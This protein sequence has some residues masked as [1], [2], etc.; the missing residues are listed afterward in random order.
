MTEPARGPI[1][2]FDVG[3][4]FGAIRDEAVAVFTGLAERGAF[5]LG[6]ELERFEQEFAEY[7]GAAHCVGICDGT[8]ALR[9]ALL[10]LDV[11]PG[12]EVVTA[13]L[14]FIAT[15][16]AIAGTGARVVL[17]DVDPATRTLDPGAVGAVLTERTR[18]VLPVHLY[19]RPAPMA[20]IG[21]LAASSG[22]SVVEDAAQAHGATLDGVRTGAL[23]DAAGFSF[24]PT[25][26]LGAMGDG[27]AVVCR[28][29]EVA[30]AVRSL[31]H[32]GA[33]PDD[34]NRHVRK[35]STAR[36]DN[37]QAAFLRLKLR[38]LDA[39]NEERRAAAAAYR[40][41]LADLP[42]TLPPDDPAD[43]RQVFHLFVVE[44]DERDRVLAE[45]RGQGI[46]AAIHYPTPVH[47]QPAWA[48]LGYEQGAFPAAE[49]LASRI[50]SLP[51]FPGITEDEID[52]VA[53][54]LRAAL[55]PSA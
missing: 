32:H 13:P 21:R 36:L 48:D 24:Y 1:P 6:E 38:R 12:D 8:D 14:T 33:A 18:A 46:G 17:A 40:E 44:V 3:R 37:L 51:I 43:G 2:L 45:L 53:A 11:G 47:L 35:G 27:G 30:A 42:L 34:A 52:R 55:A 26:N 22:A 4:A 7:C 25:K 49:R 41:R 20:E 15:A 29:A 9:L 50:L 28:D 19:G 39:D 31:R 54:A 23:G 10:G 5:S 16:E